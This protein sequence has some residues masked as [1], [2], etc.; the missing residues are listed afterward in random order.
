M[1]QITTHT[2]SDSIMSIW[3]V[4]CKKSMSLPS[5]YKHFFVGIMQDGKCLASVGKKKTLFE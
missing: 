5:R 3:F 1:K 2:G 4:L